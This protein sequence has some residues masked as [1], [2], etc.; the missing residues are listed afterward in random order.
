MAGAVCGVGVLE[1]MRTGIGLARDMDTYQ[2]GNFQQSSVP[3]VIIKVNRPEISPEQA[4]DIQSRWVTK[5][6]FGNRAPAVIPT[7]LDVSAIAWTP[8]DTQFLESKQY[9]AAE[10]CWWFGIDPRVLG[11]AASGQ[12]LTY[13]NIES[14]YVDLQR[15]SFLPWTSRIEAALGRVLPRTQLAK[16]D[17]S[18]MLRTTLQDRYSAYKTGL[19]GGWITIEEVRALENLGPLGATPP[20]VG[21]ITPR[22]QQSNQ[23]VPVMEGAA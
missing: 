20:P 22:P 21:T 4:L 1:A 15:M 6:G 11:L 12:S 13:S 18:P 10:V 23:S 16:F 3:P 19:E 5:H 14:T 2:L 7:S 9:M 17:F 8:E